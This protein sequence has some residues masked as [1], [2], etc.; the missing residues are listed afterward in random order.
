MNLA[1][2]QLRI[3]AETTTPAYRSNGPTFNELFAVRTHF[4]G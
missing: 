3:A 2:R 1:V 4:T